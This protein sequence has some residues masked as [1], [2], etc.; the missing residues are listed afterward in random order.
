MLVWFLTQEIFLHHV[1][2]DSGILHNGV[3]DQAIAIHQS[4]KKLVGVSCTDVNEEKAMRPMMVLI[5]VVLISRKVLVLKI[6]MMSPS[7]GHSWIDGWLHLHHLLHHQLIMLNVLYLATMVID[8]K[9][10]HHTNVILETV[11]SHQQSK[12]V[13]WFTNQNQKNQQ[14]KHHVLNVMSNVRT[15]TEEAVMLNVPKVTGTKWT[16]VRN[17]ECVASQLTL[18]MVNMSVYMSTNM[19]SAVIENVDQLTLA[20]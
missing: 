15:G 19:V 2:T 18:Q 7:N 14:S 13:T 10:K 8:Q 3:V 9:D 12:D 6:L 11:H 1:T 20:Q 17:T 16:N 5:E 4:I